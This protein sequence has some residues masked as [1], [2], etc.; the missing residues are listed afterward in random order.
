M[1]TLSNWQSASIKKCSKSAEGKLKREIMLIQDPFLSDLVYV[2][3]VHR[4]DT[5][6]CFSQRWTSCWED[7]P[8]CGR[9]SSRFLLRWTETNFSHKSGIWLACGRRQV[10]SHSG[11]GGAVGGGGGGGSGT[12]WAGPAIKMG[13]MPLEWTHYGIMLYN[14]P[15]L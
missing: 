10:Y 9:S 8:Y 15:L 7:L 2:F 13:H 3:L 6:P 4:P 11:G 1:W 14:S 5:P 12:S